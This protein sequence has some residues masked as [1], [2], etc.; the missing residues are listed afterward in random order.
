LIPDDA[1]MRASWISRAEEPAEKYAVG[2]Q[3]C[4]QNIQEISI[5]ANE[6]FT[7]AKRNCC[8]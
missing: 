8:E 6:K 2:G 1:E 4:R 7:S 5:G 3:S